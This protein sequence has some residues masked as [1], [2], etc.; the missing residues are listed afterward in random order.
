VRSV[1]KKH[2][3]IIYE[4]CELSRSPFTGV[5]QQSTTRRFVLE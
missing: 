2:C 5:V 3:Q 1:G 4:I